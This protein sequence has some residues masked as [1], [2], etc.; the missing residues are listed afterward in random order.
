[1]SHIIFVALHA[2][3]LHTIYTAYHTYCIPCYVPMF[4]VVVLL[5]I[6]ILFFLL[7]LLYSTIVFLAVF[8]FSTFF[9][10]SPSPPSPPLLG[11]RKTDDGDLRPYP[12]KGHGA[13]GSEDVWHAE[14]HLAAQALQDL[15]RAVS[16]FFF[17]FF[18]APYV[19]SRYVT[20]LHVTYQYTVY[21][22]FCWSSSLLSKNCEKGAD[23]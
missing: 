6:F 15:D 12:R 5:F 7:M 13:K 17:S 19:T 22:V 10:P 18:H 1:M 8:C 14:P 9:C 11:P 3:V 23:K 4:Y 2:I 16:L 21:R 20:L